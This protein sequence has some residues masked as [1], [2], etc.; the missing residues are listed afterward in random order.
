MVDQRICNQV[1]I[2]LFPLAVCRAPSSTMNI[3]PQRWRLQ[4]GTSLTSVCSISCVGLWLRRPLQ[5]Q[6]LTISLWREMNSLGGFYRAP[7][8]NTSI[9]CDSFLVLQIL[10]SGDRHLVGV[11]VLQYL[12]IPFIFFQICIY[13]KRN[14][15]QYVSA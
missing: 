4:V 11:C 9:S 10:F 13:S 14:L 5:Q 1:N 7:L 15:L 8:T 12:V 3:I 2:Y 6:R